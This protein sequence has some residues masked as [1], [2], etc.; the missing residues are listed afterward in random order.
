MAQ[1]PPG[2]PDRP[3]APVI[4]DDGDR[5]GPPPPPGGGGDDAGLFRVLGIIVG[6]G[7]V[8]AILILPPISILGGGDD[9]GGDISAQASDD[10]P[11]LPAGLEALSELYTPGPVEDDGAGFEL[12]VPLTQAVTDASSLGLYAYEGGTWTRIASAALSNDGET[13]FAEV[14]TL[15]EAFAVLR[16]STLAGSLALILD[17]GESPD[18][19]AGTIASIVSV[20]AASPAPED[21]GALSIEPAALTA[22]AVGDAS[23]LL[24][25]DGVADAARLE[26][27]LSDEE[28]RAAHVESLVLAAQEQQADGLHLDYR[29]LSVA[30]REAFTSF[31]AQ[32]GARLSEEG[33]TFVVSVP[34]PAGLDT[35][36]YDWA[37]IAAVADAIW[38]HGPADPI[39]YYEQVE[40][41]VEAGRT[42]GVDASQLQLVLERTSVARASNVV[43]RITLH[44]ALVRASSIARRSTGGVAPGDPVTV[45]ASQLTADLGNTGLRWDEMARA[46]AYSGGEGTVWLENRFSTAYRLDLAGRLGLGGVV[47][48]DARADE[49]LADLWDTVI[50]WVES[51]GVV[52]EQ[53]Y[54]PYLIPCWES[55]GGSLEGSGACWDG[56]PN[57][58][59]VTW[60]AP[61]TPGV[62]DVTL[63]VSDGTRF[64]GQRLSLRVS[65]DGVQA[66]PTPD[67]TSSPV[68]SEPASTPTPEPTSTPAPT[69]TAEPTT[70]PTAEPTSE[71]TVAPTPTPTPTPDPTSTPPPSGTPSGPPG[72]AGNE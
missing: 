53:P 42:A 27:L 66:E 65:A 51:G 40:G 50:S 52:L 57:S 1:P 25:V 11:S 36:A 54:G 55:S 56:T 64:V 9:D 61:Q 62:Y 24:G 47:V 41:A 23:L 32:L 4:F 60:R 17:A 19:A 2:G 44:D 72:P 20:M 6:L 10:F 22:A 70:A 30:S 29:G 39:A 59:L 49:E 16:R 43:S 31:V 34:T 33:L 37:A 12:T 67:G 68:V 71:P 8:I 35:G 38:L 28:Q 69:A 13:A 5:I 45:V 14:T 26:V 7:I 46:V 48:N 58:G 21:A 18:P 63:V 3:L 15:P